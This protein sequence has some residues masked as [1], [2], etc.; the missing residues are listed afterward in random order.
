MRRGRRCETLGSMMT[1]NSPTSDEAMVCGA[2]AGRRTPDG[3]RPSVGVDVP[4]DCMIAGL[5]FSR[6]EGNC[7]REDT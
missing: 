3:E 2:L 5:P 1:P 4:S 6:R 7:G